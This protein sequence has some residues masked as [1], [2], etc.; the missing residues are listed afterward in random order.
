MLTPRNL[1]IAAM[2]VAGFALAVATIAWPGLLSGYASAFAVMLAAS[3]IIDMALMRFAPG[4]GEIV[5]VSIEARFGGFFAGML[6]Y[7]ALS[8]AFGA[9]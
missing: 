8:A 1:Y 7:M 3:F 4:E 6:I 2:C 5:P 9:P